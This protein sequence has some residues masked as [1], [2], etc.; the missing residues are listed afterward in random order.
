MKRSGF[1]ANRKDILKLPSADRE[2]LWRTI[3]RYIPAYF[4]HFLETPS[5]DVP[6]RKALWSGIKVGNQHR[7]MTLMRIQL[8]LGGDFRDEN[9]RFVLQSCVEIMQQ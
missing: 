5:S 6:S 9:E 2:Q 4:R 8:E 7:E 3:N 1:Q